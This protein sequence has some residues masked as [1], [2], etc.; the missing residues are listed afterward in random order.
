M[1]TNIIFNEADQ[2]SLPVPAGTVSGG[3]VRVGGL[4]GV[5]LTDRANVGVDPVNQD[6]TANSSYNW[7]GGNVTGN[8]TVKLNGAAE[9]T[10]SF[11][12]AAVGDPIYIDDSNVL[13]GTAT[14]NN[15]FGH[16]L[17]T[18][19]AAEGPVTVRIAN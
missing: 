1:A 11:A 7:G 16:A 18:K 19:A 17:S 3:P 8:A 5:A 10:V 6:G 9:F 4:N 15:L 14:D 13:S 2:L 12:V